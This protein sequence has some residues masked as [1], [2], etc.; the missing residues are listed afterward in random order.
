MKMESTTYMSTILACDTAN[1]SCSVALI[2]D[3]A[4]IAFKEEL[5]AS[6]QAEQLLPLTEAA[7]KESGLSYSDLDA[8]ATTIGPGSFT[9]V[10]I[11][12]SAMQGIRLVTKLPLLGITTLQAVAAQELA[13]N[14]DNHPI[15][16]ILD[17]RRGQLFT[18]NFA[19][20]LTPL[21]EAS[22][23]SYKALAEHLPEKPFILAGTGVP[24]IANI[25]HIKANGTG[26]AHAKD[27]AIVAAKQFSSGSY[28]DATTPLYIRKPDAKKQIVG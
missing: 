3:N 15:C 14:T 27:A 26:I 19:S 16:V 25:E 28:S 1:G 6:K 2:K 21:S 24:L 10:R 11:G 12:L 7:L 9:G 22:L 23:I 20:D 8:L 13:T 18:Q 4:I 5:Q 17:A